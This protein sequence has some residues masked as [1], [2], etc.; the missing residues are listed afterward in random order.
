MVEPG[1]YD[2]H[3]ARLQLGPLIFAKLAAYSPL[4]RAW[5]CG[6]RLSYGGCAAGSSGRS[7]SRERAASKTADPIEELRRMSV[8]PKSAM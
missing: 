6:C 5:G 3:A 7:A 4:L 2:K 8:R 1:C